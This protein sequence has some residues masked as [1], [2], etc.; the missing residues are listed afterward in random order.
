MVSELQASR[1]PTGRAQFKTAL[2]DLH[3]WIF[4]KEN[5]GTSSRVRGKK[6]KCF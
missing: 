2:W 6:T 5:V 3:H 4:S 1:L